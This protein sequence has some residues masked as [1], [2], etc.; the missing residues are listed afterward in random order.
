MITF[1]KNGFK[2]FISTCG[3]LP[4][5]LKHAPKKVNI[6]KNTD[7]N[8]LRSKRQEKII[9]VTMLKSLFILKK[10]KSLKSIIKTRNVMRH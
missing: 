2:L 6:T 4:K 5:T 7:M 9:V 10:K 1:L 8:I 3:F